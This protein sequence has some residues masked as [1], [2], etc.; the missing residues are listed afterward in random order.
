[1]CSLIR[2]IDNHWARITDSHWVHPKLGYIKIVNKYEAHPKSSEMKIFD[3]FE[4]AIEYMESFH[5]VQLTTK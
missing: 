5:N 1:M 4:E 2:T 3:T